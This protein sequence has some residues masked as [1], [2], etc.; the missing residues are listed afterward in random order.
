MT[1]KRRSVSLLISAAMVAGAIAIATSPA[2]AGTASPANA[3]GPAAPAA[4]SA[5]A[6]RQGIVPGGSVSA[7]ITTG[8][9]TVRQISAATTCYYGRWR[10]ETVHVLNSTIWARMTTNWCF[11]GSIVT[12]HSTKITEGHDIGW[13]YYSSPIQFNCY[14]AGTR[15]C[16]GNHEKDSPGFVVGSTSSGSSCGITLQQWETYLGNYHDSSSYFCIIL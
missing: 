6:L 4:H 8:A 16:S 13:V 14:V 15:S 9:G 10:Q 1:V 3:S 11:N 12:S 5:L 7:M 2:Y